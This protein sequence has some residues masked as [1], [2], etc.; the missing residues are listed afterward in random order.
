MNWL[1]RTWKAIR[2]LYAVLAIVRFSILIPAMLVMTLLFA[3]QMADALIAE[4]ENRIEAFA[5]LIAT[6]FAALIV[7]YTARTMLRS[8][9][10][11]QSRVVGTHAHI[12]HSSAIFLGFLPY[13]CPRPCSSKYGASRARSRTILGYVTLQ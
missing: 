7:W 13:P 11:G 9:F 5:S 10:C 6:L 12:P 2:R 3:D 4:S 1:R 8:P